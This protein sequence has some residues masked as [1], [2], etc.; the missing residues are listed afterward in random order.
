MGVVLNCIGLAGSLA[1]SFIS[2]GM[3][4]ALYRVS[5]VRMRIRADAPGDASGGRAKQVLA[6]L[7][8]LDAMVTAILINNNIAAYAGSYF[9]AVQLVAWNAPH[10]ELLTTVV[11]TPVF[12]VLT[13]SLPKQLAYNK[14]DRFGLELVRAFVVFRTLLSPMVWVLNR[15]SRALRLFL[16]TR[17]GTN[18]SQSQRTLLMEHLNAGVADR[19][20]S[21]EQNS[22]ALRIMQLESLGA[23]D[24]MIPLRKLLLL[25]SNVTRDRAVRTM[26]RMR[27]RM[28]LLCDGA[29]RPTGFVA[30]MTDLLMKEGA[31]GDPAMRVAVRLESIRAE[32][33]IPEALNLFRT[34]HSRAA[35]VVRGSRVEGII[36][37]HTVLERI[38]GIS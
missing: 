30:T 28:A 14:A 4:I 34:K 21:A 11:I 22:M 1:L 23:G 36:T 15:A 13:E 31:G 7:E 38:A 12:F 24:A 37:T 29:G 32:A 10:A 27:K 16:G 2:S 20:L 35:L 9:L 8:R 6:V 19:V 17:G 3:E 33:S 26:S 18:L 5:R 25:P